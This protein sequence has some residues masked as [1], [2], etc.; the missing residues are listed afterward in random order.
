MEAIIVHAKWSKLTTRDAERSKLPRGF[1][2]SFAYVFYILLPP[3]FSKNFCHIRWLVNVNTS[4]EE[5]KLDA[6][7]TKKKGNYL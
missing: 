6:C 4:I 5:L 1:N 7:F 3:F 2:E